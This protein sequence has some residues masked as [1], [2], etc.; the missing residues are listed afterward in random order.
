[1]S[2]RGPWQQHRFTV[3]A[4]GTAGSDGAEAVTVCEA[5]GRGMLGL[6]NA[7]LALAAQQSFALGKPMTVLEDGR[8]FRVVE[9]RSP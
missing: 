1:M 3:R 4:P 7:M 8:P 5:Q 6:L 9:V 2:E